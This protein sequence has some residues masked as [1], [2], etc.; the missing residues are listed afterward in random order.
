M[1][2]GVRMC[3]CQVTSSKSVDRFARNFLNSHSCMTG[4]RYITDESGGRC[5]IPYYQYHMTS[6]Q[7]SSLPT[8][9]LYQRQDKQQSAVPVHCL[10]PKSLPM[11]VVTTL[12]LQPVTTFPQHY[13]SFLHQKSLASTGNRHDTQHL[14]QTWLFTQHLCQ[15]WLFTQDLCQTQLFTQDLC[16]TWL[17]TQDLAIHPRL[18]GR[19]PAHQNCWQQSWLL[20]QNCW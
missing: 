4:N 5:C 14:C 13:Y 16:Q 1:C 18:V 12:S 8:V 15:T 17:L 9:L 6:S 20:T 3:M 11:L 10:L 7:H 19:L 2:V